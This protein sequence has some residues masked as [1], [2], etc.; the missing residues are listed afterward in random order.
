MSGAIKEVPEEPKKKRK[1]RTQR[2]PL[3]TS[4]FQYL[5]S[6]VQAQRMERAAT[7][8]GMRRSEFIRLCVRE[9]LERM[10]E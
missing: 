4:S 3:Y 6:D 2:Y 10:G 1:Y 7:K 8:M 5:D 9:K